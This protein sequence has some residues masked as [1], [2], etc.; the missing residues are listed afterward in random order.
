MVL[1]LFLTIITM[2][3]STFKCLKIKIKI[4]GYFHSSITVKKTLSCTAPATSYIVLSWQLNLSAEALLTL[5]GRNV[6]IKS[7]GSYDTETFFLR[8]VDLKCCANFF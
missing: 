3:K 7:D 2:N 6:S 4:C 5:C 1:T 8:T